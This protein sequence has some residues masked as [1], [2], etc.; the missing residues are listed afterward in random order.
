MGVGGGGTPV[1]GGEL[2]PTPNP[3][4]V[5]PLGTDEKTITV[6]QASSLAYNVSDSKDCRTWSVRATSQPNIPVNHSIVEYCRSSTF[7]FS[8]N[9]AVFNFEGLN[10]SKGTEIKSATLYS[11]T[12]GGC[13]TASITGRAETLAP[14]SDSDAY[15]KRSPT[16]PFFPYGGGGFGK[17]TM[18]KSAS[19]YGCPLPGVRFFCG[20]CYEQVLECKD[21]GSPQGTGDVT[22]IIGGIAA[23]QDLSSVSLKLRPDYSDSICGSTSYTNFTSSFQVT[24]ASTTLSITYCDPASP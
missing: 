10:I 7:A 14:L 23:T 2:S 11:P 20:G 17:N 6:S 4:S 12:S 21:S 3:V 8:T 16:E 19:F 5:C 9:Y 18:T 24:A 13:E 1:S 15:K 22:N